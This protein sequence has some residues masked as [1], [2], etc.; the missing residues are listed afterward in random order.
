MPPPP[1]ESKG[2]KSFLSCSWPSP[3]TIWRPR[4][5]P[6]ALPGRKRTLGPFD[7]RLRRFHLR[8]FFAN[9]AHFAKQVRHLHAG[10]RF[11]ERGH[12]RRN[13]GDVAGQLICAG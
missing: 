10:E 2:R 6:A 7:R 3:E 4:Q 1:Q 9:E 12:L 13:F 8:R 11:E 5:V